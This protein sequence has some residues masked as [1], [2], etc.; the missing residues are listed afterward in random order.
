MVAL[1]QLLAYAGIFAISYYWIKDISM[2]KD[3]LANFSIDGLFGPF[4]IYSVI[5]VLLG[6]F[7]LLCPVCF[8]R[9]ISQ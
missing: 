8:V 4:L 6:I 9:F 1:A 5:F 7:D 2:V 3:V